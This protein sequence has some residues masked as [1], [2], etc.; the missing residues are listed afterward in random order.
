MMISELSIRR[1]VF[2]TVLSLLLLIIGLMAALKLP[3][4]EYPDIQQSAVSVNVTYRGANA[5]VIENRITQLIENEVGKG[6]F[7]VVYPS[8][9]IE[10]EA[11]VAVVEKVVT[12]KGT[13]AATKAY[14]DGL[15][16]W[17]DLALVT[18][19]SINAVDFDPLSQAYGDLRLV[20]EGLSHNGGSSQQLT[21]AVKDAAGFSAA[22]NVIGGGNQP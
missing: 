2:A 17:K 6:K 16:G 8:I 18:P 7:D 1:P 4:R 14:A 3:I 5:A 11:P 10:A 20:F 13:A 15:L 19:G 12:K 22:V 21:L 9:T